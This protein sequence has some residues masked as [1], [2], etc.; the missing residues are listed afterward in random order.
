MVTETSHLAG[1]MLPFPGDY[2]ATP[3]SPD[4]HDI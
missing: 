2:L 4:D 3:S 1:S